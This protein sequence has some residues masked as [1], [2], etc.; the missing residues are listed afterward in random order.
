MCSIFRHPIVEN[1]VTFRIVYAVFTLN[2]HPTCPTCN[3]YANPDAS[4]LQL[5][6]IGAKRHI[7]RDRRAAWGD[8]RPSRARLRGRGGEWGG[9]E[10]VTGVQLV[11]RLTDPRGGPTGWNS[12]IGVLA[13]ILASG[14][15]S[16]L[17]IGTLTLMVDNNTSPPKI[18]DQTGSPVNKDQIRNALNGI[19]GGSSRGRVLA[20]IGAARTAVNEGSYEKV[21]IGGLVVADTTHNGDAQ[22]FVTGQQGVATIF[23]PAAPEP[24]PPPVVVAPAP[25]LA[26]API[27][28]GR[29]ARAEVSGT[30]VSGADLT[31]IAGLARRVVGKG[32]SI[33]VDKYVI[34]KSSSGVA[35]LE[36][37]G[38]GWVVSSTS[39]EVALSTYIA[40]D[41]RATLE[42]VLR[43]MGDTSLSRAGDG[44]TAVTNVT[45][46]NFSVDLYDLVE[47]YPTHRPPMTPAKG[48]IRGA[49][50]GHV[51]QTNHSSA[52]APAP[53]PPAAPAPG[54]AEPRVAFET[55]GATNNEI[56]MVVQRDAAHGGP[57]EIRVDDNLS[58]E[59]KTQLETKRQFLLDKRDGLL[60][61]VVWNIIVPI[62]VSISTVYA[63]NRFGLN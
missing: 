18:V 46:N 23:V 30:R 27:P 48:N 13:D 22:A 41:R 10:M 54:A 52:T 61:R 40:Q 36:W 17:Q 35:V 16:S 5:R 43:N 19:L 56:W 6:G 15:V 2:R 45:D 60:W 12:T 50:R 26:P 28:G 11:N 3:F 39:V 53:P 4:L 32:V 21:D 44:Q 51:V 7:G 58:S 9:V 47:G 59:E 63:L 24:V 20:L 49:V 34:Q 33:Q 62:L 25:P 31:R 1:F 55:R 14:K 29:P 37:N 38:S 42:S 8:N 57:L